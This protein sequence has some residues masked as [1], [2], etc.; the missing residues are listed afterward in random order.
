MRGY[1]EREL[2][3]I[4]TLKSGGSEPALRPAA[5]QL[6]AI[7]GQSACQIRI[8]CEVTRDFTQS[9]LINEPGTVRSSRPARNFGGELTFL[10]ASKANTPPEEACDR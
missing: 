4:I 3:G 10:R 9:Q 8:A 7:H 2:T 6:Y 5:I 1:R